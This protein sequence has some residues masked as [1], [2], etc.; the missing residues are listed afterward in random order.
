MEHIGERI[1]KK[2]EALNLQLNDLAKR[3]GISSSGLSQIEKMK[4]TPSLFTLKSIADSLNTTVGE[5]LGENEGPQANPIVKAK[6]IQLIE[7][8][9]SGA[10]VYQL[11]HH[12]IN[13]RMDNFL[14]KLPRGGNS[15]GLF[16][17]MQGQHF[18][19]ITKGKAKFTLDGNNFILQDGDN[20]SF[21]AK[22]KFRFEN[23]S[24]EALEII[25]TIS[26]N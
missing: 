22:S 1:K 3:V 18:C 2:R 7:S 16:G 14:V 9:P 4:A 26:S 20:A 8:N 15:D 21:V 23:E 12:Q 6:E 5:L 25:W 17:N 11:S 24:W 13:K 10:Q 19:H